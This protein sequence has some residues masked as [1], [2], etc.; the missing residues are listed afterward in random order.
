MSG[1]INIFLR[2]AHREQGPLTGRVKKQ[3]S[4]SLVHP[5]QGSIPRTYSPSR[6]PTHEKYATCMP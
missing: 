3:Q 5:G 2:R 1:R 4:S 6:M